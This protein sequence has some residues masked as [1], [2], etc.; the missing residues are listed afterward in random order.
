[1]NDVRIP[2]PIVPQEWDKIDTSIDTEQPHVLSEEQFG[3]Y[4]V[5]VRDLLRA[6]GLEVQDYDRRI[7]DFLVISD[8]EVTMQVTLSSDRCASVELTLAEGLLRPPGTVGVATSVMRLFELGR[9]FRD[10]DTE[11]Y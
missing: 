1:M 11:T 6:T 9:K 5:T 10:A 8:D 7:P 2:T 3:R 4:C